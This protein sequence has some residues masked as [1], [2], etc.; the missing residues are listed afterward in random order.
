M[1]AAAY[2]GLLCFIIFF[3]LVRKKDYQ[4]DFLTFFNL[5]FCLAYPLPGFLLAVTKINNLSSSILLGTTVDSNNIQVILAVFVTY[6]LVIIGFSAKS[7]QKAASN[8]LIKLRSGDNL[9]IVYALV[10]L[11][12]SCLSIYIYSSQYGGVLFTLSN[13]ALLRSTVIE[14][15]GL[16]FFKRFLFF[17]FMGSYLL[18]SLLF[19]RRIKKKRL[20]LYAIFIG[21]VLIAFISFLMIATRAVML[22][23]VITFYLVYVM[24]KGKVSLIFMITFLIAGSIFVFYGK[25]IFG[26]LMALP[27]GIDAVVEKFQ[28]FLD[29]K[30]KTEVDLADS[31]DEFSFPFYSIYAALN[32]PYELRLLN[33]WLYGFAS[34]LPDRILE[35]PETV[36]Y[37][38]TYYLIRSNEYE[39]PSGF[40]SSC[41]YSLSWPGVIIFSF[42]YGWIGRWIQSIIKNHV[43]DIYWMYFLYANAALVW[44]DFLAYADTKIILQTHFWFFSSSF[45]LIAIATKISIVKNSGGKRKESKKFESR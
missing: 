24:R 12:I 38:N 1:L 25:E 34:F 17:S 19:I 18:A 40:I 22:R 13:A 11:L 15:G 31:L 7:A 32:T 9:I 20:W 29:S 10:L 36:S 43:E 27:D 2:L 35:A 8:I 14:A 23:Y 37:Y 44:A 16:S 26:S 33:D 45:I 42:T 39:I 28:Y 30:D 4:F 3:E 41:F 6:F 21:S 5:I